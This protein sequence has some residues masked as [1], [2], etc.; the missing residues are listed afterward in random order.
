M[1]LSTPAESLINIYNL[2]IPGLDTSTSVGIALCS[3]FKEPI[4]FPTLLSNGLN[5]CILRANV[6]ISRNN[7]L[8]SV[9][10]AIS[11][12]ANGKMKAKAISTEVIFSLSPYRQIKQSLATFGISGIP[13]TVWV[14]SLANDPNSVI[15]KFLELTQSQLLSQTA[16][17]VGNT[18]LIYEIYGITPEELSIG[19]LEDAITNRIAVKDL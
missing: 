8:Q 3:G 6:V 1:A 5:L 15:S 14:V 18:D 17:E 9:F 12:N 10:K 2:I 4:S 11:N 7:I 13:D 16:A 19:S